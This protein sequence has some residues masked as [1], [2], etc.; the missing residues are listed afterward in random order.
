MQKKTQKI[1]DNALFYDRWTCNVCGK[2]IFSGYFCEECQSKIEWLSESENRCS[3]CGRKTAYSVKFC[4]NCIEKNINFDTARSVF[5]YQDTIGGV[6]QNFKYNNCRY[7][8]KYFAEELYK[9]YIK[10]KFECDYITF[11]PM[12]EQRL[13]ERGYNQAELLAEEFSML[14][15][16]EVLSV[17]NKVKETERQAKLTMKER[18]KNLNSSFKID[19]KLV[20]GK[21]IL[22]IDDVLTTGATVETISKL[23][24]TAKA[25]KVIVL[26][27]ASV[28]ISENKV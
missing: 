25:S 13:N 17:I 28:S 15:G 4:N 2:E 12:S 10:E 16:L 5:N 22:L 8:S 26:T 23:L 6:I 27:V 11:V 1:I 21:K 3:H 24:K 19:K 9:I 14:S 18:L 7:L 20:K